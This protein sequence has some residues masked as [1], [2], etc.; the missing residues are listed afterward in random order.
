M[1][2]FDPGFGDGGEDDDER[3]A[4]SAPAGLIHRRPRRAPSPSRALG[5][6]LARRDGLGGAPHV[7]FVGLSFLWQRQLTID[8]DDGRMTIV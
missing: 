1:P 2:W 6:L 3:V 7:I 8:V 5:S 4:Q